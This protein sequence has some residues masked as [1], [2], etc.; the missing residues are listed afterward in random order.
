MPYE[1]SVT[2]LGVNI[3]KALNFQGHLSGLS[4]R[5]HFGLYRL[6]TSASVLSFELRKYL[7]STLIFP[8]LDYC[9]LVYDKSDSFNTADNTY[10]LKIQR[11]FNAGVRFVYGL[12]KRDAITLPRLRLGWISA[13]NRRRYF[14]CVFLKNLIENNCP[15]YLST[16]FSHLPDTFRRSR[17]G[18][19]EDDTRDSNLFIVRFARTATY[20]Q[21]FLVSATREWN[22]LPRYLRDMDS[23]SGFK[24]ALYAH[25]LKTEKDQHPTFSE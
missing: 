12:R 16:Q 1:K 14:K 17:R 25:F 2:N 20:K 5:V 11:I 22:D 7:V 10:E 21:S 13:K 4:S 8:Y 23:L 19:P 3:D 15:E 18:Q 24:T 6:K 9:C